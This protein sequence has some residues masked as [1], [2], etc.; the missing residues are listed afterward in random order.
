M[1]EITNKTTANVSLI[2]LITFILYAVFLLAT[3]T[4][5]PKT[6]LIFNMILIAGIL[7][8]GSSFVYYKFILK[9]GT[10]TK[11]EKINENDIKHFIEKEPVTNLKV[12]EKVVIEQTTK[13]TYEDPSLAL[14]K[15]LEAI[16]K[17][18]EIDKS[19]KRD[20]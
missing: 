15:A 8:F 12:E 20:F 14:E 19:I 5:E 18:N 6:F 13:E 10:E 17:S 9:E 3:K 1:K 16:N 4:Y 2:A 11:I 7:I